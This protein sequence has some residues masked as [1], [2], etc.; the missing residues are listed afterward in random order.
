MATRA[1]E[2]AGEFD[3]GITFARAALRQIDATADPVVPR[4]CWRSAAT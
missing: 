2:L 1:A 3:R 4:S